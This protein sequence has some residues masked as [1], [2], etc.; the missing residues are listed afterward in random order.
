M[1]SERS[2]RPP[3]GTPRDDRHERD[4]TGPSECL[5]CDAPADHQRDLVLGSEDT[6]DGVSLCSPCLGALR[7]EEWI[8]LRDVDPSDAGSDAND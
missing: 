7:E 6:L 1:T 5:M 8:E 3:S 4:R 2:G